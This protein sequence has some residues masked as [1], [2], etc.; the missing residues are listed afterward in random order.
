MARSLEQRFLAFR[1]TGD[2]E[3]MAGIFDTTAPKLL[4]LASHLCHDPAEVEDLVQATFVAVL[5]GRD[6]Y[7]QGEPFL[8]WMLGILTHKWHHMVRDRRRRPD[9]DRL[10]SPARDHDP[11]VHA[12]GRELSTVL[13]D[14]LDHMAEPY[15][16]VLQLHLIAGLE[17]RE[18]AK[19][20]DRNPGT[21]RAQLHR[22]L[23]RLRAALPA[24]FAAGVGVSAALLSTQSL[25]AMRHHVLEQA[26]RLPASGAPT[27][28]ATTTAPVTTTVT[29]VTMMKKTLALTAAALAVVALWIWQ[30]WAAVQPDAPDTLEQQQVREQ[31][32]VPK[33]AGDT[34]DESATRS[35]LAAATMQQTPAVV[36][37]E[38]RFNGRCL[39][40]STGQPIPG[41]NVSLRAWSMD[42]ET[43]YRFA[44]GELVEPDPIQTDAQGRFRIRGVLPRG[45]HLALGVAFEKPDRVHRVGRWYADE[46]AAET[47]LGDIRMR[48]GER[49]RGVV[50]DANDRPV[51]GAWVRFPNVEMDQAVRRFDRGATGTTATTGPDGK[52]EIP[53]AVPSGMQPVYLRC[54]GYR[55]QGPG[56][57]FLAP[58]RDAMLRLS[59][60]GNPT[61]EGLVTDA[62]GKPVAGI[63][64][65]AAL[66]GKNI[67]V[68]G[69]KSGRDGRFVV[70]RWNSQHAKKTDTVELWFGSDGTVVP[71][72]GAR[73]ARWGERNLAVMAGRARTVEVV[74]V[75]KRDGKPVTDFGVICSAI[76]PH[77][78][79]EAAAGDRTFRLSGHHP[80]GRLV[81]DKVWPGKNQ[82]QILP[83]DPRLL[84]SDV[85]RFVLTEKNDSVRVELDPARAVTVEIVDPRGQPVAG[86]RIEAV[87]VDEKDSEPIDEVN[88]ESLL[89]RGRTDQAGRVKLY[90][91]TRLVALTVQVSGRSHLAT[92]VKD[93]RIPPGDRPLRLTVRDGARLRGTLTPKDLVVPGVGLMLQG[94]DAWHR[95]PRQE[96]K[97]LAVEPDGSFDLRHLP[98]GQWNVHLQ[99]GDEIREPALAKVE[100]VDGGE[101]AVDLDASAHT[102]AK[103]T[104]K[105]LVAGRVP[106]G[107]AAISLY[108]AQ[109]M[110]VDTSIVAGDGTFTMVDLPAG[111]YRLGLR[112]SVDGSFQCFLDPEWFRIE[113]GKATHRVFDLARR[114]VVVRLLRKDETPVQQPHATLRSKTCSFHWSFPIDKHGN[115]VL[116]PAPPVDC[117]VWVNNQVFGELPGAK[118]T[119]DTP[120]VVE[121]REKSN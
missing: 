73:S 98:P 108:P 69:G 51:Q 35:Q 96:H 7:R 77:R 66:P 47:H 13:R 57:V 37:R 78:G 9:P 93:Q 11:R 121:L 79:R 50:V 80:D 63:S 56:K 91:P 105:V 10:G 19:R 120:S 112:T 89:A 116:D 114:R 26:A 21:V 62:G 39:D 38:V 109:G 22:G 2:P 90:V 27:A 12:E 52:F 23:E 25:A 59:M 31:T 58:G 70:R 16:E 61:I 97:L 36:G 1:T 104:G 95:Y 102:P 64:V 117:E 44:R 67:T 107:V 103:L 110:I 24:G 45:G 60:V 20:L 18:I 111:R 68:G 113:P 100:L 4:K 46:L 65:S 115:L 17:P 99:F 14:R 8:P 54:N 41:V 71:P 82:I 15:A 81:V 83:R 84:A 43:D 55:P 29:T 53:S 3:V 118:G 32:P 119:A 5:E 6:S 30:P 92:L 33:T 28:S 48:G 101:V 75:R 106:D 42:R 74:V 34:V 86:S 49:V 85:V 72:T 94:D 88:W 87:E 40:W 76:F